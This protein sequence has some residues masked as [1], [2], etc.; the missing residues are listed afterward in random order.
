M[1]L[2]QVR[3]ASNL[4]RCFL[5]LIRCP[6]SSFLIFTPFYILSA[7]NAPKRRILY[8][9]TS[10]S[11]AS[12]RTVVGP[13]CE[14]L[15]HGLRQY[16]SLNVRVSGRLLG[17]F[18]VKVR[19]IKRIGLLGS[20]SVIKTNMSK[21]AHTTLGLKVGSYLRCNNFLQSIA[22]KNGWAL[23]SDGPLAPSLCSGLRSR[24]CIKRSFAGSGTISGPG[25]G[26][27][28][29]NIFLYISLGFSS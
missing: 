3:P 15:L 2:Y 11:E 25:K 17:E 8:T 16:R 9:A 13:A 1:P 29:D 18:S 5:C 26:R 19:S 10:I 22:L 12:N 28:S 14:L 7:G 20:V 6:A 27:G 4:T 23:I 21:G 24:S